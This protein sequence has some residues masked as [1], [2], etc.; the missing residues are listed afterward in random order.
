MIKRQKI[1]KDIKNRKSFFFGT[2]TTTGTFKASQTGNVSNKLNEKYMKLQNF[3]YEERQI[4]YQ[5]N[6]DR[7]LDQDWFREQTPGPHE[8]YDVPE[9]KA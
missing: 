6:I 3:L 4:F 7:N 8:K 2:F 5:I 9:N 1:F